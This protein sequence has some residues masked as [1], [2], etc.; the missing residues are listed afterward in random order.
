LALAGRFEA[1]LFRFWFSAGSMVF[2]VV[3][4]VGV[5]D[6]QEFLGWEIWGFNYRDGSQR[7]RA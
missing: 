4:L 1:L 2:W 5:D 7:R 6:A 3:F